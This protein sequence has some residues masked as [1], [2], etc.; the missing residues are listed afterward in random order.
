[1]KK[2]YKE[3]I[4]I[5][6]T[7][8]RFY[9]NTRDPFVIARALGIDIVY[10]DV[11][12]SVLKGYSYI[13]QERKE[14]KINSRYNFEKQKIICAHEL[15]HIV[16]EHMGKTYYMD[17]DLEKEYCANLFAVALL[18]NNLDFN[19]SLM[20]MSNYTLQSILNLNL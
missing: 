18:F 10:C 17:N 11:D 3:E 8:L 16:L 13:G 20:E 7:V 2:E 19:C 15:G 1:M 14:I 9:K 6:A 5:A 4:I 12:L